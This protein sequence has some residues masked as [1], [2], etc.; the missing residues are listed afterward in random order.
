MVVMEFVSRTSGTP[1][2]FAEVSQPF[3]MIIADVAIHTTNGK[4][5][6]QPPANQC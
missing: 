4:S 2:G 5:W 6:A 3:G 1:F